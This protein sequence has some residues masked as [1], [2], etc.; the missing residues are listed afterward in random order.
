MLKKI[1][2]ALLSAA[3]V[4]PVIFGT[5]SAFAQTSESTAPLPIEYWAVR[6][7]MSNVAVSPNG[8]YVSFMKIQG[9]DADPVIEIHEIDS[10]GKDPIRLDAT[11]MEFVAVN[12]VGDDY[13]LIT[14]RQQVRRFIEDVNRGTYESRV[15]A[16]NVKEK[17]WIELA[18]N[19]FGAVA[20]ASLLTDE[21]DSILIQTF[22]TP[23]EGLAN[24]SFFRADYYKY[25]LKTGRRT[26]VLR[27][28]D[29]NSQAEFD[30]K[31]RPRFSQGYDTV[32]K[33]YVYYYRGK[34]D[35]SWKEIYRLPSYGYDEELQF[36]G[37]SKQDE[38][39]VYAIAFNGED[40]SA[41][42]AFDTNKGAFIEKVY[43]RPDVDILAVVDSH[44]VWEKSDSDDDKTGPDIVGVVYGTDRYHIDWFDAEEKA[45]HEGLEAAIP[46]GYEINITS[47]SRDDSV[48]VVS[49]QGPH[50]PGSFYLFKD[51]QLSYLG[52]TKPHIKPED[53]ADVKFIK[54]PT[55]DGHQ[56]PAY[57]TIPKGEGP[58]PLIVLPHGG[59]HVSE[60]I[61]W[62]EWSQFLANNGYLVMQP[63]Y[64][65]SRGW[66]LSH[67][68]QS[69]AQW[70]KLMADDKD[71]GVKYLIEQGMTE[72][73]KVAMFGWSYG[74]YA[75]LAAATRPEV[76]VYQCVIAG[77]PVSDLPQ[78]RADFAKGIEASERYIDETYD[79][80]NPLE[81][82]DKVKIP[83]MIIHGDVDQRVP[84]YHAERM[85]KKLKKFNKDSK[86]VTLK[87]ADHFS[88][89][90]FYDHK[91]TLYT[92]IIDWLE[93]RGGPNGL[94]N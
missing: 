36:V 30:A 88:N 26:T 11:K 67:W 72:P 92:E 41:L 19:D 7:A 32:S 94:K 25:D 46:N 66:G 50:D 54:Y 90:L 79:G 70:G 6:S 56:I 61:V 62:D 2:G 52:G 89:T 84:Y 53:L 68:Q 76:D 22:S 31:G 44:N 81:H 49:N 77:A 21:P 55:R 86:L 57:L 9:K 34:E 18:N 48:M 17:E 42:W 3:L 47:A 93:N 12:W 40:R 91:T 74:G 82:A 43:Q 64:R 8:K 63:E 33:D 45:L 15:I 69:F 87:K 80:L 71:D 35:S 27:G 23:V 37:I 20:I 59:P 14:A 78:A 65:G 1:A 16:Y 51:G 24:A 10:L 4:S 83:V 39:I 38:N 73:D 5:S 28:T 58:W 85:A 13:L 75:A 60:V 29:K